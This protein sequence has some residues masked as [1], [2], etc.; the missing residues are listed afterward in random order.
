[1]DGQDGGGGWGRP[2]L[3]MTSVLWKRDLESMC[4]GERSTAVRPHIMG[5]SFP[6]P[7]FSRLSMTVGMKRVQTC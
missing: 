5:L 2:R 7:V 1:M 3:L 4:Y 6:K